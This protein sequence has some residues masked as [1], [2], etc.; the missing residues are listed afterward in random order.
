RKSIWSFITAPAD[1]LRDVF[2]F[3]PLPEGR[4]AGVSPPPAG[5]LGAGDVTAGAGQTGSGRVPH[6]PRAAARRP[7]TPARAGAFRATVPA[8]ARRAGE[9][10][11]T[12]GLAGG[13]VPALWRD[14]P[15]A[16]VLPGEPSSAGA[17]QTCHAE[18]PRR[19]SRSKPKP[20]DSSHRPP[21]GREV[22]RC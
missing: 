3:P 16:P 22:L 13:R 8:P 5:R 14:V 4:E 18:V 9:E 12:E 11:C 2:G 20:C 6:P 19:A 10:D 17:S 7:P 1:T 21:D 15:G